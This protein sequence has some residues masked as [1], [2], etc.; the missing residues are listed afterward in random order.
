M[1]N[2]IKGI[3][4]LRFREFRGTKSWEEKPLSQIAKYENGKAHEKDIT[5]LGKFIVVNSKFISTDGEIKKFTNIAFCIAKKEDILIVL[6][7][8]PKGRAIAKCFF[9]DADNLYTVNQRICKLTPNN[10]VNMLLFYILNRNPYFLA[11]DDGVKQTNLKKEDVLNCPV[12]LPI[13]ISEQQKIADC[14]SSLDDLIGTEIEKLGG[15][16]AHKKGLLQQLFPAEDKIMPQL[17]FPEFE[18]DDDWREKSMSKILD[19]EQPNKYIVSN[20]NYLDEGTP[21]LTA[22]K[23][24]LLGY[25]DEKEGIYENVPVIIFD[26]FTVDKKYV[27]FPFK[28][29]SS[30]IKILKAK[31]DDNLKFMFELMTQIKFE[32]VQHKRY[33]ISA[34]QNLL[35]RIPDV[36][37]QQKIVNCLTSIDELIIFQNQK[38]KLLKEHKKG[39]MQQLFPNKEGN[40]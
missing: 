29:K 40:I 38:V 4:N 32:A 10:T 11:F 24:F 33:Y 3:P 39:L 8:V 2:N 17:R 27:N 26:D 14:L 19:Y 13:R 30:A 23:R 1:N 28:I 18:N 31:S 15:L 34:Y 7:D 6:S 22:N 35:I 5:E 9:V 37:E 20:T 12:L 36:S 25:T 16:K 21:V